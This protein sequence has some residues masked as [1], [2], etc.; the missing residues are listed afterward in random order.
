VR[1][2]MLLAAVVLVVMAAAPGVAQAA[3]ISSWALATNAS[4]SADGN[5]GVAQ[6]VDF[7]GSSAVFNGVDS[8][9]TVPYNPNLSPG[10]ADVSA[11]VSINTTAM[12]GT[13]EADF[14][15]LRATPTG[16][17][18]KMEL[19]PHGRKAQ[20]HCVWIGTLARKTLHAGPSL[21][22][23]A[24][25][26]ITCAKTTH[27]VSLAVDGVVLITAAIDI[28]SINLRK[29]KPFALGYK[30]VIG[31]PDQDKYPGQMKDASVS[32]G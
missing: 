16:K 20:A 7:T 9:I 26:T 30:P 8:R 17:M 14:D 22:D 28:G 32:I 2:M 4:D 15:L 5:D 19:F 3:V 6:N 13:G 25:H 1:R 12:P 24:W 18:Y 31:Q 27:Q 10:A 29:D 21:N 23:G 11:T